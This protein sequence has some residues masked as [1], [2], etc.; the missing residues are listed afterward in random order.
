MLKLVALAWAAGRLGLLYPSWVSVDELPKAGGGDQL[1][2]LFKPDAHWEADDRALSVRPVVWPLG[3]LDTRSIVQ[4][5]PHRWANKQDRSVCSPI[6]TTSV[7]VQVV[8]ACAVFRD[9]QGLQ[10]VNTPG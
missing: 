3:V 5:V 10:L 4:N 6:E 7:V 2:T 8:Q 1:G 9:R